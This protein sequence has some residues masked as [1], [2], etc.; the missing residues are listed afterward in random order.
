MRSGRGRRSERGQALAEFALVLP[1]L[2]L[3]IGGIIEFGR[4]WNIKQAVTDAAR[5]GA[6]YYV[7]QDDLDDAGKTTMVTEKVNERL[8]LA[9]IDSAT[10][11][12]SVAGEDKT[13]SIST[14]YRMSFV[15]ALMKWAGAPEGITI[16]TSATM[17]DE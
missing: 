13:V 3:L 2:M 9:S 11:A 15:S 10:V 1:L 7:I 16:S 6:R 17:R 12:L 8:A 5:E 14:Q 4:A